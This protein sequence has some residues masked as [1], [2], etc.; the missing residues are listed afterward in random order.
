MLNFFK[1]KIRG[2]APLSNLSRIMDHDTGEPLTKGY[3]PQAFEFKNE[4]QRDHVL[5]V[6]VVMEDLQREGVT[7]ENYNIDPAYPHAPNVIGT[8]DGQKLHIFVRCSRFPIMPVLDNKILKIAPVM[9]HDCNVTAYFAAVGL[10]PAEGQDG[11]FFVN[12][13]GCQRLE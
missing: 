7:V 13:R 6:A 12:Y 4:D 2:L 10:M 9:A 11:Y 1:K 3:P 8:L 5:A